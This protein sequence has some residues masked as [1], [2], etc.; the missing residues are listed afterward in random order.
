VIRLDQL[1]ARY[2]RRTGGDREAMMPDALP[3]VRALPAI[4]PD[5]PKPEK[6]ER[7]SY[8]LE[9]YKLY[10]GHINVMFNYFLVLS[11]LIANAYIQSM[12]KTA[13]IS[14]ALSASIAA[15]GALLAFIS[16][17]IHIRSRDMLD[18]IECGLR[19]EEN[20]LFPERNG[21]LNAAPSRA[22]W[23]FRHKY[24]FP[25]T[26]CAFVLAF[27][28]MAIYSAHTYVF[29]LWE[30]LESLGRTGQH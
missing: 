11:G 2:F 13:D 15:F 26:Y 5:T 30:F 1:I 27:V 9:V 16:L 19:R 8:L 10:H 20:A 29:D 3:V 6:N 21:F 22:H 18:T 24:Q 17:L 28:G 14:R 23:L 4:I 12:L 7:L 25:I